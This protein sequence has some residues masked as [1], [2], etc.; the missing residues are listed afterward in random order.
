MTGL[1]FFAKIYAPNTP[2]VV[3]DVGA[4][5]G[6]SV[7]SFLSIFPQS[8]IHAFEPAPDNF[9]RLQDLYQNHAQVDLHAKA[10]GAKSGFTQLH[11]NNYDATHSV[12]PI[13]PKEINRWADTADISEAS[14]LK[15]E[16]CS[17]DTFFHETSLEKIDIL[18]LDV[19]GGELAALEGALKTLQSQKI[20]CL[21]VEVE[22]RQLYAGQPLAWD[23]HSFLAAQDYHFIN[24]IYPNTTEAGLLSWADAIY[25]NSE[26][27]DRL[28]DGH[29]AGK[30]TASLSS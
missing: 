26:I 19:Q 21:F 3:L 1:E 5:V 6:D 17:I 16:Q 14:Q 7:A 10:V 20:G 9:S 30:L 8:K 11:L 13:N 24:F 2:L 27:W 25:V 4:H 22:F 28:A 12:L 15:V 23:I 18:K 29:S